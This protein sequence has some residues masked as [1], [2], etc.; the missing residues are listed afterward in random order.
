MFVLI[1]LIIGILIGFIRGGSFKGMKARKISLFPL[2]FIGVLLQLI[3]HLYFYSGGIPAIEPYLSAINFVSYILILLTLVFNL[4]DF[5]TILMAVGMT[6][7]FIVIFINGGKMPVAQEILEMLPQTSAFVQSISNGSNAVYTVMDRSVT[8]LWFLGIVIPIPYIGLATQY[9]GS[10]GGL[11]I[12]SIAALIGLLGW[13]QYRMNLSPSKKPFRKDVSIGEEDYIIG[14]DEDPSGASSL[15][16]DEYDDDD[17]FYGYSDDDNDAYYE[18]DEYYEED[19]SYEDYEDTDSFTE[20]LPDL[21]PETMARFGVPSDE[22]YDPTSETKVFTSIS[23][24]GAFSGDVPDRIQPLDEESEEDHD[25]H[26]GFFTQ[27]FRAE[28]VKEKIGAEAEMNETVVDE[29]TENELEVPDDV[30]FDIDPPAA[31]LSKN[32]ENAGVRQVGA[33]QTET[34]E[35]IEEV[36]PSNWTEDDMRNIWHQVNQENERKRRRGLS[37]EK[38]F[39]IETGERRNR[40]ATGGYYSNIDK[41]SRHSEEPSRWHIPEKQ[42]TVTRAPKTIGEEI[43]YET[44]TERITKP[45]DPTPVAPAAKTEKSKVT[46]QGQVEPAETPVRTDTSSGFADLKLA[47]SDEER[48]KAGYEKI[49]LDVE[50]REVTF[51]R[52]KK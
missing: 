46:I 40:R 31:E 13:S 16:D 22:S 6:V 26:S 28:K 25:V 45:K 14:P 30:T 36:T 29:V 7:S 43:N 11:S 50:G 51:W 8:S 38:G 42:R 20:T 2:G 39:S 17:H 44:R 3:L 48:E 34:E 19:D 49:K 52:K 5:W 12:G 1:A 27:T 23:D 33:T 18:E 41:E 21:S 24:L 35:E 4:D 10:T 37:E 32:D 9:I 47:I 15:F